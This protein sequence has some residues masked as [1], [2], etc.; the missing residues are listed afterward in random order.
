MRTTTIAALSVLALAPVS[1]T[2]LTT[3]TAAA[4]APT[5]YGQPATIVGTDGPDRLVG[6]PRADVIVGLAGNDRIEGMDGNDRLCG[7]D[8]G[9]VVYGGAGDDRMGGGR[10]AMSSNDPPQVMT[11]NRL[12]G[13]PGDDIMDPGLDVRAN[14]ESG[15]HETVAIVDY[16]SSSHAVKFDLATGVVDNGDRIVA[17]PYLRLLGTDSDDTL[18]GSSHPEGLE[19]G[20]G[21]DLLAGRAGNDDL[22]AE[23]SQ[24]T[25]TDNDRLYG[26]GGNDLLVSQRPKDVVV[27]GD[28]DDTLG[29]S[30]PGRVDGG[31]GGD[32]MSMELPNSAAVGDVLCGAGGDDIE[33]FAFAPDVS[34]R[35]LLGVDA[36]AERL[37]YGPRVSG[38][39]SDC[40]HYSLV[41]VDARYRFEGT[42]VAE[43]IYAN[44]RYEGWPG[45]PL[46]AS[47]RGGDDVVFG[48]R[49]GNDRIDL[50][51]GNDRVNSR[52]SSVCF[53]WERGYCGGESRP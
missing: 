23:E 27:G 36:P 22:Q 31:P 17:R 6:T 20:R 49:A 25:A 32:V 40:E 35:W 37:T 9:D 16:S 18:L 11:P 50:G 52:R 47:L 21:N 43:T 5:C 39:I 33:L 4:A 14:E 34:P 53:N 26:G 3:T 46:V 15:G 29:T 10:A 41:G 19:G 24:Q 44:D 2:V 30:A 8:G 1:L 7:N 13:G 28:G 51:A 45:G 38:R 42:G 12:R 48:S